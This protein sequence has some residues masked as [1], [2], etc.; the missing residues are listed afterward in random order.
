VKLVGF[1]VENPE[2]ATLRPSYAIILPLTTWR[3]G[4]KEDERRGT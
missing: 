2:T 1:V 4:L 3:L